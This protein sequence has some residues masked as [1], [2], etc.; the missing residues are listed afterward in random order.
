M[1]IPRDQDEVESNIEDECGH[2]HDSDLLF[3]FDA[4]ECGAQGSVHVKKDE[5]RGKGLECGDG[6]HKFGSMVK[7]ANDVW[8]SNDQSHSDRYTKEE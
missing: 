6:M 5:S 1:L 3:L 4:Y 2:C 8:R 7:E